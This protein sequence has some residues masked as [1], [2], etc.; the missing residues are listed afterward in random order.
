[1]SLSAL[2][3]CS[4]DTGSSPSGSTTDTQVRPRPDQAPEDQGLDAPADT[5]Q[6]DDPIS[7]DRDDDGIIVDTS[8]PS[9]VGEN[10]IDLPD[11]FDADDLADTEETSDADTNDRR[12][13]TVD[14]A[15]EVTTDSHDPDVADA[16]LPTPEPGYYLYD[17]ITI[18]GLR[19]IA[20]AA[21]HPDGSYIVVL[22]RYETVHVYTVADES[23]VSFD[24]A[25][26]RWEDIAF[27]PKGGFALLVGEDPTSIPAGGTIHR[28]DDAAWRAYVD[29]ASTLLTAY[30]GVTRVDA[31]TVVEY[32]WDAGLPLIVSIQE[33]SGGD[34]D[35]GLWRFNPA[36]GNLTF[37]S[38]MSVYGACS[39]AAFITNPG[40]ASAVL[41]GCDQS[42]LLYD[43]EPV[44]DDPVWQTGLGGYSTGNVISVAA[45][46]G[47]DYALLISNSGRKVF[48]FESGSVNDS[49]D[50]PNFRYTDI[51]LVEF[52]PN[53]RRALI[54][55]GHNPGSGNPYGGVVEYR[56]DLYECDAFGCDLTKVF[57]PNFES[58]PFSADSLYNFADIA[59]SPTCDGGVL[60]GGKSDYAGSWGLVVTFQVAGGTSCWD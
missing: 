29:D 38:H 24:V 45:H 41:L 33:E 56:H 60:V 44:D 32:P 31:F 22:E 39:D 58:P 48:R 26:V 53:G 5:G 49:S 14:T 7:V 55:G 54:A 11:P 15:N 2:V 16:E 30:E 46:R 19:L 50:A 28:F 12:V 1:M 59:W 9:D 51:A 25:D 27:D 3:A 21:Y 17:T 36:D 52:Q 10:T 42:V 4:E 6:S 47:G 8:T 13:D 57:I 43:P 37:V 40:R 20:A 34:Y 23:V 35:N 18:P